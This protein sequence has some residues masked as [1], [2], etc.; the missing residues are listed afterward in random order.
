MKTKSKW[1]TA[2]AVLA[3]SGSMA[4][5]V[6]NSQDGQGWKH[7][8]R[9]GGKERGARFAQKLNLTDQQK[10]QWMAVEKQFRQDNQAFMQTFRQ[11]KMDFRAA[12]EAGD[13]AK[14]DALKPTFDSQR[15]QM[16]QLRDAN[17][18]KLLAI[19][20]ADQLAKYQAMKAAHETRENH[21]HK[22]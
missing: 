8:G 12:K 5:A 16:K 21:E 10:E 20:N 18:P 7:E 3:L 1:I 19:L 14:A 9:A 22:Q 6:A 2:V 13:T 15:A 11:T 17:E 4:I